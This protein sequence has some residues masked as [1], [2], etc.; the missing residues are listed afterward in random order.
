MLVVDV[1]NEIVK[2]TTVSPQLHKSTSIVQEES[3]SLSHCRFLEML[4]LSLLLIMIVGLFTGDS[5]D[6]QQST[7]GNLK[8]EK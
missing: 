4:C 5:S 2:V 1:T 6:S 3:G 7:T 8:T